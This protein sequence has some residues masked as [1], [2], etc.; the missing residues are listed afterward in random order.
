MRRIAGGWPSARWPAMLHHSTFSR[1]IDAVLDEWPAVAA[2][3]AAA[4]LG[5]KLLKHL[6]GDLA[7]GDIDESRS[8]VEASVDRVAVER[9]CLGIVHAQPRVNSRPQRGLR[10]GV[11]LLVDLGQ[12]SPQDPVGLFLIAR[13]LS[14][15]MRPAGYRV[16]SRVNTDLEAAI[17]L[18]HTA[19]WPP[20]R[21]S[22]S[23]SRSTGGACHCGGIVTQRPNRACICAGSYMPLAQ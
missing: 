19:P 5:V 23:D 16:L 10:P 7:D 12:K 15:V 21:P 13:R 4:Q 6:R 17:A 22:L 1:S 3:P 2:C 18:A 9:A 8:H 20:C 11:A 14:Q